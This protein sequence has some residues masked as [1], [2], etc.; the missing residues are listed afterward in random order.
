MIRQ[1]PHLIMKNLTPTRMK[2]FY[3]FILTKT[4]TTMF[5]AIFQ[6]TILLLNILLPNVTQYF[7]F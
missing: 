5:N 7:R 1:Q 2:M 3:Y 4:V 6:T